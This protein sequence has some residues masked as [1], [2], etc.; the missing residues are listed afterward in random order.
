[1]KRE[2]LKKYLIITFFFF[3]LVFAYYI[4]KERDNLLQDN[5]VTFSKESGFYDETISVR[6]TKNIDLPFGTEI[7]YTLNGNDPTIESTKY[8][9]PIKLEVVEKETR[10]YPLKVVAYHNDK[11]SN[12]IEKTYVIDKNIKDNDIKIISITSDEKNLYDYETGILVLGKKYDDNVKAGKTGYIFGNVDQ[13]GE[14]WEKEAKAT[15]FQIDGKIQYDSIGGIAVS[16][17]RGARHLDI[18]SFKIIANKYDSDNKAVMSFEDDLNYSTASFVNTYNSFKLRSGSTDLMFGNVRS[19]LASRLAVQS[20]FDGGGTTERAI[21]FLNG[22]FYGIFDIQPTYSNS[23]LAKKFNIDDKS[24]IT[25]TKGT[26][27]IIKSIF[28]EYVKILLSIA[29]A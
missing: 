19:R 10:I 4:Y 16:G 28:E 7:Y 5:F 6:L 8:S 15:I 27:E 23:Y 25:N 2:V 24:L 26:E 13:R 11:Y 29:G 9:G 18:K 12:I 22:S 17:G 1:M 3:L 20:G 21:V 14:D